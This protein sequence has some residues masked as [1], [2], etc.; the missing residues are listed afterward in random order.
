MIKAKLIRYYQ[1]DKVTLGLLNFIDIDHKPIF[2]LELPWR[3]N[4]EN[5]SCIPKSI[6]N[7]TFTRSPSFG[8]VY[9]VNDVT[10]R[11]HIL[12]H[13]GNYT[14]DTKGCIL[15]GLGTS[16]V[17]VPMVQHSR[18]ALAYIMEITKKEDFQ[19]EIKGK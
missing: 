3:N 4:A 9:A 19:L 12:I 6:Y 8:E 5:E 11:S 7:C 18:K 1:N 15:V 10:N 16:N 13:V 17:D 14:R 2:T